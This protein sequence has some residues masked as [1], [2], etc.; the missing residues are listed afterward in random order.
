MLARMKIAI[1]GAGAL[2]CYYGAMLANAGLDLRFIMRSGYERARREG[3]H[4][5][6]DKGAI[7][8]PQATICASGEECGPV[9]LVLVCWK[10]S[11]NAALATAL[12]PLLHENTD[13][14][15]LQN[16]MG[17]VEMIANYVEARHVYLGL[18]FI[19]CMMKPSG[20]IHHRGGNEVQIAP[21]H[22]EPETHARA[23]QYSELLKSASI[24]ARAFE[25]IEEIL[26]RKL[27][28]NIPFNGLCLAHGGI[29][30][31]QRFAMPHEVERARRIIQEVAN[32]AALRGHP[33]MDNLAD[34]QIA[35]TT[36]MGGFI[37]S[38]AMDYLM[39]R[40]IEYQN[41]WGIPLERAHEVQA[42]VPE[43]ERLTRDI[44]ARMESS[45]S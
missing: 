5:D 15:S 32:C 13:V 20:E 11:S 12:P 38:S 25:Q 44:L 28:W 3:I 42:P 22:A 9:D 16:G 4:V 1:L 27:S 26:W 21:L 19:S 2:G 36:P 14:M 31:E 37:P 33:L 40:P 17:N 45:Q 39:G 30:I 7:H 6:S 10:S 8:L 18:C 23:A 24:T 29:S 43:W 34:M 35:R 41:I